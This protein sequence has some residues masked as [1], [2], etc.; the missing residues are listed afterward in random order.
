[1][2]NISN[3]E[4]MLLEIICEMP[5]ISGYNIIKLI[6]E[7]G[8]GEWANIGQT[9]IYNSLEKLTKKKLVSFY[10]D[11]KKKGQGPDPK[12]FK[13]NQSGKKILQKKII[14]ALANC[15]ERD[16]RF[17]LALSGINLINKKSAKV[18]LKKRKRFLRQTVER[19][20]KKYLS[21]GGKKLP[22]QAQALF[23]HPQLLIEQE[24][25]FIDKLI[26]KL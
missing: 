3:S 8:Y 25:K 23:E 13:I 26:T 16:Q 12:N 6:K 19:L 5:E 4:L 7:R 22:W 17:D 2:V 18:A 21:Q 9:S 20:K 11:N 15:R 10:I 1:M 14:E 24:I